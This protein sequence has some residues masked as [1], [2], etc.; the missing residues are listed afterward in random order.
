T[1]VAL[2]DSDKTRTG[3]AVV[4]LSRPQGTFTYAAPGIVSALRDSMR[5]LRLHQISAI[6]NRTGIGGPAVNERGEIIGMVSLYRLFGDT[7]GFVVPINYIRGLATTGSG[8]PFAE[9]AT[10]RQP[11][12]PF[13]PALIDSKRLA[14]IV[15][16]KV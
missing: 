8:T 14:L 10:K 15:R 16:V 4:V 2:G 12:Q 6:V 5:G 11:I 7:L 13:D 3:D 9:F 1:E